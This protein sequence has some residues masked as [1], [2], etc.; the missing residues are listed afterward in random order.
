MP[1]KHPETLLPVLQEHEFFSAWSAR[2]LLGLLE[3]CTL[4]AAHVGEALWSAG[5]P[6]DAAFILITGCVERSQHVRPQGHRLEQFR[7]PGA[8]MSLSSLVQPWPHTSTG[9][10]TAHTEVLEIRREDFEALFTERHPAAYLLID[11]IAENLV[12][13]MRDANT[14]L[15]A[16]FGHPAETLRLLRRRLR[17]RERVGDGEDAET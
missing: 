1:V 2:E 13:E 7:E 11:A 14:R 17:E 9:S 10:P 15:H 3:R 12:H 16:V 8:L 4:R 5:E 6:G